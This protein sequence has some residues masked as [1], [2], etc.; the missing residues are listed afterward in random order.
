MIYVDMG[1]MGRSRALG[2]SYGGLSRLALGRS[3]LGLRYSPLYVKLN[4]M[5]LDHF[6]SVQKHLTPPSLW[7]AAESGQFSKT[8]VLPLGKQED[9]GRP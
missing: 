2:M 5:Q 1:T 3:L 9:P 6:G 4:R 7:H 8:L